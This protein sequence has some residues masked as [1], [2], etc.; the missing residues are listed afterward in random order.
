ML[1]EGMLYSDEQNAQIVV[2]LLKAHGI[3][4][5]IASPGSTNIAFVGSAQADDFFDIYSAVDERHAA[6]MACGLAAESRDPVVISCTGATASRNYFPALTEAYYRQLPILAITSM[7]DFHNAGNL[8]AQWV[9]RSSHPVDSL[10]LSVSCPTIRC[11]ADTKRCELDV[12]K[13]ILELKRHGGG[14]VHINLETINGGDFNTSALP[15]VTKIERTYPWSVKW[16]TLQ[17][18]AKIVLWISSH[19]KFSQRLFD[20]VE[21]FVRSHNAVVLTDHTSSYSGVGAVCVSLLAAQGIRGKA[22]YFELKPDLIVHIGNVS[23]DYH[24]KG[25]LTRWAPVWRVSADGDVVDSLGSL[26][27][28]FEM[29]EELFFEHY[30]T[31]RKCTPDYFNLWHASLKAIRAKMPELPF[32]NLSIAEV[33]KMKMP[34]NS[35]LHAAILS[36][37]RSLNFQDDFPVHESMCNVGGFG[38]DGCVSTLIGAS[39]SSPDRLH[40]LMTGDMA[41]FYDLNAIGNRHVGNNVRILLVNNGMAGEMYMPISAGHKLGENAREYVCSDRH[42]GRKSRKLVKS[43]AEALGFRYLSAENMAGLKD[44]IDLFVGWSDSPILL[45]CFTDAR[46]EFEALRAIMSIEEAEPPA[47]RQLRDF[48]PTGVKKMIKKVIS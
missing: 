6:Y 12:N 20:A 48:V 18:R 32:S 3:R 34:E 7:Q 17:E 26:S 8:N 43:Y 9:D 14:P 28:V 21:C 33:L 15:S 44:N 5:I 30:A 31:N 13:A 10:K 45:E 23:G 19:V 39:L 16:P 1:K 42:F 35:V 22:K 24:T 29:P 41:F 37:L 2:A 46:D 25:M 11:E 36:S 38:I 27:D 47:R 4:K 40:F